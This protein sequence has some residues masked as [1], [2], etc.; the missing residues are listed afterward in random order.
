MGGAER[1]LLFCETFSHEGSQVRP[2]THLLY[3]AQAS[4]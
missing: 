2:H 4:A 1:E 3:F